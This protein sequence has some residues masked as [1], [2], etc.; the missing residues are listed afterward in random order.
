[1]ENLTFLFFIAVLNFSVAQTEQPNE[2]VV[3]NVS[4]KESFIQMLIENDNFVDTEKYG[5]VT[6]ALR[7]SKTK[8]NW[9]HQYHYR[10]VFKE[11]SIVIKPYWTMN[12]TIDLGVAEAE[13]Q[14]EK[15]KYS[16]RKNINGFIHQETIEMLTNAGYTDI[17]YN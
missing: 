3:H 11:D 15:W 10:I 16:T 4:D 9:S 8:P 12:I 2:I 6:T 17:S 1:M 5:V 14:L 7:N 13:S